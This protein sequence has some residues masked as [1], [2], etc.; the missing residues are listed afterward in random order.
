MEGEGTSYLKKFDI[1]ELLKR[2]EINRQGNP[3]QAISLNHLSPSRNIVKK[4]CK[5]AEEL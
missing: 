4:G 1:K 5:D 2:V 3:K